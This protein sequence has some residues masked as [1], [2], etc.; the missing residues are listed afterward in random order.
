[1]VLQRPVV[2][3]LAVVQHASVICSKPFNG[4]T[5]TLK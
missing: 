3:T 5:E 2:C 4:A 1:V